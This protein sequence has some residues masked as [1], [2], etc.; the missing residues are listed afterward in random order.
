LRWTRRLLMQ[1]AMI[2]WARLLSAIFLFVFCEARLCAA[3]AMQT[4][5]VRVV[6]LVSKD[7]EVR[8]DFR[9]AIEK[10]IVDVRK[11]YA[12]QLE[13][14][15]FKLHDPIVEVAKSD[16][17]AAW[18]YSHENGKNREDWGYNNALAEVK[19][20]LGAKHYDANHVWV[21][22]SDGP[23]D[24]GRGVA[25]VTV[26]PED[27]LLGLIGQHPKQKKVARWIGGLAHELGHAFGLPHPSD[28]K[29]D[30]DAIMW[31]GFYEKYP[32]GAY[33]TDSDKKKLI[34]H[35]FFAKR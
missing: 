14:V 35:P 23:G 24:K 19:R 12:G 9:E 10:A 30:Y 17:D 26:M 20:L 15:T 5:T 27:D 6:Y 7:R 16:Q 11:W 28:T 13:G 1:V 33:F 32:D 34:A 8:A 2:S 18:F 22:Y 25:S 21:I 29:K 31:A 3:E 4:R